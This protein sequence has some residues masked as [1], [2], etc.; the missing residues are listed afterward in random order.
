MLEKAKRQ[1]TYLVKW[2]ILP[3]CYMLI[4]LKKTENQP[5]QQQAFLHA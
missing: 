4:F 1:T 2:I 3:S 5:W